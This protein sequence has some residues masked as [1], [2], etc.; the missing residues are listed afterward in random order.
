M[1]AK[2]WHQRWPRAAR[3]PSLRVLG[4][5][6]KH[7]DAMTSYKSFLFPP[8]PL[9]LRTKLSRLSVVSLGNVILTCSSV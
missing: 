7:K 5:S 8:S 9:T 3:L 2:G 6:F 1:V 4:K